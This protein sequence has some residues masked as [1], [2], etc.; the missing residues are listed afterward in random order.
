MP[1]S[2]SLSDTSDLEP[3]REHPCSIADKKPPFEVA[4]APA[5]NDRAAWLNKRDLSMAA[6]SALLSRLA[7]ETPDTIQRTA[8]DWGYR[9]VDV[10]VERSI[11]V[12][13]TR[14]RRKL[15]DDPAEPHYLQTVRGLGYR[16][17]S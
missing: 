5:I 1:A 15:E 2:N 14:L 6:S 7:Y 17:Q 12:Q 9:T 16:L 10:T 13:V 4:F 3:S 11:D 8:R